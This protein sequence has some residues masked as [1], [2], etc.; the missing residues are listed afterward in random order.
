MGNNTS[1][2]LLV[3]RSN[4]VYK[5]TYGD[6][7]K[8]AMPDK[9]LVLSIT[10]N[11]S[12]SYTTVGGQ[13]YGS[14]SGTTW[15]SQ[16]STTFPINSTSL[17][18]ITNQNYG[19]RPAIKLYSDNL[20]GMGFSGWTDWICSPIY[21]SEYDNVLWINGGNGNGYTSAINLF[22]YSAREIQGANRGS[23]ANFTK[24]RFWLYQGYQYAGGYDFK[25]GMKFVTDTGGDFINTKYEGSTGGTFYSFYDSS[26]GLN[27][28]SSSGEKDYTKNTSNT[29]SWT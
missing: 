17:S 4:T 10:R 12:S 25:I 8:Q 20:S 1:D 5:C 3:E 29:F 19:R 23:T 14:P 18:S 21:Y 27:Q 28:L 2:L 26:G 7:M 6:L 24:I 16:G 15:Y 11:W 22:N 13:Y 9:G